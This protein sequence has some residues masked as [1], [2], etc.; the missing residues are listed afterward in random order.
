MAVSALA[1]TARDQTSGGGAKYGKV[2]VVVVIV[3]VS[4]ETL[5]RVV[6]PT[7]WKSDW[8]VCIFG[9]HHKKEVFSA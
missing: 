8:K 3:V 6:R 9:S 1:A 2:I 4:T 5:A 7:D